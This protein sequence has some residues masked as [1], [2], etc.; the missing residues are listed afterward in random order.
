VNVYKLRDDDGTLLDA[1]MHFDDGDIVLHARGGSRANALNPDYLPALRL[2]LIRLH[3]AGAQVSAA[4]VDSR[5]ARRVPEES[6]RV[7]DQGDSGLAPAA[8][9][10][11]ISERMKTVARAGDALARGGNSTKRLRLRLAEQPPYPDLP[12]RLGLAVDPGSVGKSGRLPTATLEKI[13]AEHVW[14]AVQRLGKGFSGHPFGKS[15]DYDL[16]TSDGSRLP[17]KAVF[18]IAAT[19]ALGF[20]VLPGHFTAGIDSPCFRILEASGFSIQAKVPGEETLPTNRRTDDATEDT[21]FREGDAKVRQHLSRER[22]RGVRQAKIAQFRRLNNGRLFCERC[23]FEPITRYATDHADAC[24]EVHHHD[25]QVQDMPEQHVTTLD[26]LQCLCA[27]CHRIVHSE[28]R[29]TS[30]GHEPV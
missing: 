12:G 24:I 6:R 21:E 29:R 20:P 3:A 19:E 18:G 14:D 10:S 15:T 2:L 7:L 9:L 26:Q 1:A 4:W 5:V 8:Q 28:I 13:T 16:V 23:A 17:P 27:N 22:A 11:L 25:V 30:S